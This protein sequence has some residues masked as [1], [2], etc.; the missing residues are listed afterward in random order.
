MGVLRRHWLRASCCDP[1]WGRPEGKLRPS[2]SVGSLSRAEAS[3]TENLPESR[4]PGSPEIG[5]G[6]L[7]SDW[8]ECSGEQQRYSMISL[9][10]EGSA[11]SF[12]K[13]D[14]TWAGGD[15]RS[16]RAARQA[17]G[18]EEGSRQ[19][20]VLPWQ[21]PLTPGQGSLRSLLEGV[22]VGEGLALSF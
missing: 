11:Q 13:A 14:V 16:R 5:P 2:A 20:G 22:K 17:S 4:P 8:I 15:T 21:P 3:F 18:L 1:C 6:V 12:W 9:L 19:T 7:S 10:Q